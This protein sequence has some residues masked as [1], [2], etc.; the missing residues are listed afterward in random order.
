MR[1]QDTTLFVGADPHERE[2]Q[3]AVFSQDGSLLMEKRIP[4]KDLESFV[5]SLPGEKRVAIESVGF[6]YPITTSSPDWSPA[7]SLSQTRTTSV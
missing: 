7:G 5:Q 2:S 4:T 1:S 6:V 3:L